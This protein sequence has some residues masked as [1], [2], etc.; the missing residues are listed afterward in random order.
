[1]TR[2]I[3][4]RCIDFETTDIPENGGEI[5][6]TGC[7]DLIISPGNNNAIHDTYSAL[8]SPTAGSPIV[9]EARAAHHIQDCEL[10]GLSAFNVLDGLA[11]LQCEPSTTRH[12]D[13]IV[14]HNAKFERDMLARYHVETPSTWICTMKVARRLYPGLTSHSLQYLRYFL[15]LENG[16]TNVRCMPPHRAGPDTF[17]T[18]LLLRS[19]L[20]QASPTQMAEW[21]R[22]PMYY[23]VCP[24]GKYKGKDWS[25]V[26]SGY[27]IW[28]TK[29]EDMD[30]D[31]KATAQNELNYRYGRT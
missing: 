18:A 19:F 24:I 3:I 7:T 13:Y 16:T 11:L 9:P 2:P 1:M 23:P 4:L 25:L 27:L 28:M 31:I 15:D 17:L 22:L 6:E 12:A 21:T 26:D 14:A 30:P 29:A 10:A 20:D 8:F 5:I